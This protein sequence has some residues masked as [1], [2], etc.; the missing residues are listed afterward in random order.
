MLKLLQN[1]LGF[2]FF[3]VC[4]FILLVKNHPTDYYFS[5]EQEI[6]YPASS[7]IAYLASKQGI[8]YWKQNNDQNDSKKFE[9]LFNQKQIHLDTIDKQTITYTIPTNLGF[10]LYEKWLF[11]P[12]KNSVQLF[13]TYTL[14]FKEKFY[15]LFDPSFFDQLNNLISSR[16][17]ATLY[18]IE[19]QYLAHR[20]EYHGEKTQD[21][22]YY[23]ATE[24]ESL[25]SNLSKD[26]KAAQTKL[27]RFAVENNIT[28]LGQP[29]VLF[30]ILNNQNIRWRAA[31][32]TDRFY[33]STIDTIICRRYKGGKSITLTHFGDATFLRKSWQVLIDSLQG[34]T[35]AYPA[36]QLNTKDM[37]DTENPLQ[38]ETTLI[39]PIQ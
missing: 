25:W 30:P 38:W 15:L 10:N 23:I 9:E 35:Q 22:T 27:L 37:K 11:K 6:D 28:T 4:L 16:L 32:K 31:L 18:T 24:G 1:F 12:E 5:I 21:Q 3:G 26:I 2:I 13:F 33:N 17:N 34:R 19:E 14:S 7:Y 29:W 20:W 36:I 39:L 8:D